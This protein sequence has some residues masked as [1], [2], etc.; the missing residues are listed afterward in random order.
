MK[1][2]KIW[3][4][5]VIVHSPIK[6]S[7]QDVALRRVADFLDTASPKTMIP[8]MTRCRPMP[9]IFLLLRAYRHGGVESEYV[10]EF[11][12]RAPRD[13]RI[14]FDTVRRAAMQT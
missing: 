10:K 4:D 3:R 9:K 12:L 8:L 14:A 11:F 5:W 1:E 2:D 13:V 7:D 6:M